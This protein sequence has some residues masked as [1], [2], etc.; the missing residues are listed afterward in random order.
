MKKLFDPGRIVAT[1]G[2][3]NTV[4]PQVIRTV[5][6]RHLNGDWGDLCEEDKRLNEEALKSGKDRLFSHYR[7]DDDGGEPLRLYVI[8]EADRSLTTVLL[9]E[10][11]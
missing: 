10:E 5:V 1:R 7:L 11:Y 2:V 9:P 4:P 3:I 6:S 8:T